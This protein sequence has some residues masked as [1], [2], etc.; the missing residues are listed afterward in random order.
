MRTDFFE[1]VPRHDST[2]KYFELYI[3]S[4]SNKVMLQ[5]SEL[6]GTLCRKCRLTRNHENMLEILDEALSA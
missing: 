6:I 3:C 2:G 4:G 5:Q 1:I